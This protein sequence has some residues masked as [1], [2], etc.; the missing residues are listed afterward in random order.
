M[1]T[2]ILCFAYLSLISFKNELKCDDF[3]YGKFEII[4]K[5][6]NRKYILE[7]EQNFQSEETYDL[8]TGKKIDSKRVHSLKWINSCEYILTIDT[9]KSEYDE[10][11]IYINNNGGLKCRITKIY[12]NSS[13]VI[14][15]FENKSVES[16]ISKIY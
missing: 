5:I 9:L 10:S 6:D 16:V 1:K 2:F 14:T 15:S 8:K 11:D 13:K 3:H 7:R 4:N 12:G